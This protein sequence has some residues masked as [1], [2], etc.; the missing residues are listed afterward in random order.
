MKAAKEKGIRGPL[1]EADLFKE[2]IRVLSKQAGLPTWDKPSFACLS[3]RIAYGDIITKEKLTKVDKSE[4]YIKSLDIH[5][6]R[7]RTHEDTA[8]IEVEPD[9]MPRV[10]QY[11]A[12]ITKR[13][14][15]FGYKYVSMDLT[16]YTSGSMN[17]ALK[18]EEMS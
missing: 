17:M 3:S 5:Q 13:L 18:K 12:A 16:G 14:K 9:D 15:Q 7:V 2:E 6:V 4:A 10:L 8:R 1:L 11:H